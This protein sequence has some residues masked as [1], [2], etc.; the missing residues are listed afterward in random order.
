MKRKIHVS[1][2]KKKK[3]KIVEK[4]I[5]VSFYKFNSIS[6]MNTN[7]INFLY[8]F[9]DFEKLRNRKRK[10]SVKERIQCTAIMILYF[11]AYM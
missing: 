2:I 1:V 3:K 8:V 7:V 9:L 5:E 11:A 10:A 6:D 4:M